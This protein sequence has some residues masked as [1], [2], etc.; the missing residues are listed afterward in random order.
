MIVPICYTKVLSLLWNSC[1]FIVALLPLKF[2]P[3]F[4]K[5][6]SFF[7]WSLLS[8]PHSSNSDS[9][10]TFLL[11]Q[12]HTTSSP[13]STRRSRLTC[14]TTRGD[15]TT[16]PTRCTPC[17]GKWPFFLSGFLDVTI[18]KNDSEDAGWAN[19]ESSDH[20]DANLSFPLSYYCSTEAVFLLCLRVY[21]SR[22][23]W[24]RN[25]RQVQYQKQM[26]TCWL[27]KWI[28]NA[29]STFPL[30]SPCFWYSLIMW[31]SFALLFLG[32]NHPGT[33]HS[34]A[35]RSQREVWSYWD[36]NWENLSE[37][38]KKISFFWGAEVPLSKALYR[39]SFR[40]WMRVNCDELTD[41]LL[42]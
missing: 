6:S 36:A 34:D 39:C 8:L 30:C 31:A 19:V 37:E 5:S 4:W 28:I 40:L 41:R 9:F 32:S 20:F 11:S 27:P 7:F 38:S 1:C 29:S 17:T 10:C 2:L 33:K 3:F 18:W 23:W 16:S 35:V 21:V 13:P 26:T 14:A 25:V 22:R 12:P 24:E 42:K 15:T